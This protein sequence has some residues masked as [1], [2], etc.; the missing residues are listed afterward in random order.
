MQLTKEQIIEEI[1]K[2]S[3][4]GKEIFE[5]ELDYYKSL[6]KEGHNWKWW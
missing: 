5:I 1:R 4:I 6:V 2:G 3:D